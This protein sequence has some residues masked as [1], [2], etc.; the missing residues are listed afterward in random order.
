ML[1]LINE[2]KKYMP[3]PVQNSKKSSVEIHN[4]TKSIKQLSYE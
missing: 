4:Y 1:S 2:H 3:K